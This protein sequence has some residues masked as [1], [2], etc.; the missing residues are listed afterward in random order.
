MKDALAFSV[1]HDV[2]QEA[3]G[4]VVVPHQGRPRVGLRHLHNLPK[5]FF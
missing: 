3:A 4:V 1:E 2:L 5:Y